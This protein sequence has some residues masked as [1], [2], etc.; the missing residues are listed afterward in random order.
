MNENTFKKFLC[1]I[2][3]IGLLSTVLLVI[4]TINLY[5]NTSLTAVISNEE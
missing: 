3:I 5:N 1:V 4:Y 2:F